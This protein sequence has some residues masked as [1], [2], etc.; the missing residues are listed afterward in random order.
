MR[1]VQLLH[2]AVS[3]QEDNTELHMHTWAH[4][5]KDPA[6]A[7]SHWVQH[8]FTEAVIKNMYYICKLK[9]SDLLLGFQLKNRA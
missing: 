5:D 3:A 1:Q 6:W 4:I 7:L 9:M 2:E 8:C